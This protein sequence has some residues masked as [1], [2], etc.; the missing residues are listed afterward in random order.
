MVVFLFKKDTLLLIL[1]WYTAK[2]STMGF[3]TLHDRVSIKMS[4][5]KIHYN[6]M[7]F[8]LYREGKTTLSGVDNWLCLTFWIFL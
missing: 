6:E 3:Q 4:R 8:Y 2:V 1:S 5:G 7:L